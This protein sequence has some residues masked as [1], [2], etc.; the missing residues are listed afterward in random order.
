[1]LLTF[2]RNGSLCWNWSKTFRNFEWNEILKKH[3]DSNVYIFKCLTERY[4]SI[5]WSKVKII[6]SFIQIVLITFLLILI[7]FG[8]FAI[9]FSKHFL[10]F[11]TCFG[12][13]QELYLITKTIKITKI[14]TTI[15]K[16][17]SNTNCDK[18]PQ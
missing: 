4:I 11:Q 8:G 18:L 13:F 3:A 2:Y 1:M 5:S 6:L 14:R 9:W 15:N 12:F 7:F 17:G 16:K 10:L